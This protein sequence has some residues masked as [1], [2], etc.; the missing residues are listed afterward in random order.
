MAF[1]SVGVRPLER[2]AQLVQH[3]LLGA[4]R[5]DVDDP[6]RVD[7]R[8]LRAAQKELVEPGHVE[9]QHQVDRG[10][11]GELLVAGSGGAPEQ[12]PPSPPGSRP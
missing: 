4:A 2:I 8:P 6:V 5:A 12:Y 9:V 11:E 1:E 7:E 10:R 3:L